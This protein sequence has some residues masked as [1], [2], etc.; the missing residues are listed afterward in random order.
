MNYFTARYFTGGYFTLSR[1][2]WLVDDFVYHT[3]DAF[4]TRFLPH[5]PSGTPYLTPQKRGDTCA[6]SDR[7]WAGYAAEPLT[8][9][10]DAVKPLTSASD[11]STHLR[12]HRVG[13]WAQA[14]QV[15]TRAS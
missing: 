9:A 2:A 8:S 11:E 13:W 5:D 7:A 12:V 6:R 10:S 3:L 1:I 14:R 15:S 4:R